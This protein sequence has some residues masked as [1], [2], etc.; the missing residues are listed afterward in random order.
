MKWMT[1]TRLAL[2]AAG[3]SAALAGP[4]AADEAAAKLAASHLEAGTLAAG[5]TALAAFLAK[6]PAND[7]ARLGLGTIRFVRARSAA[8]I[9]STAGM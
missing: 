2:T 7:E 4:A 6:D 1:R 5:E 9:G 8:T 3:L